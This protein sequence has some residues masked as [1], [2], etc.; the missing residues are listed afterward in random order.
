MTTGTAEFAKRLDQTAEETE[1][2]LEKLLADAVVADEI[3]RPKR[4]IEAVE[5]G[6]GRSWWWKARRY[7]GF[8]A[9]RRCWP[10]PRSNASIAIR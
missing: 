9:R 10:V 3:V 2:L 7:S 1:S 4:L 5:K 6:C 8:R